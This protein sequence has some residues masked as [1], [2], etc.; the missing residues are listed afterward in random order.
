MTQLLAAYL[1]LRQS[2]RNLAEAIRSTCAPGTVIGWKHGDKIRQG[3]ILRQ[4]SGFRVEI[5]DWTD[6]KRRTISVWRI[7]ASSEGDESIIEYA[8]RLELN[9]A[10][11]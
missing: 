9:D 4:L 6:R 5:E 2:Q 1:E 8:N 7:V 3:T 10:N 11:Q